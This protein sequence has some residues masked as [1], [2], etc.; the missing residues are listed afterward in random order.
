MSLL[1]CVTWADR[2]LI[3][4]DTI[5]VSPEGRRAHYSK[6]IPLPHMPCIIAGRGLSEFLSAVA[7]TVNDKCADFDAVVVAFGQIVAD[8]RANAVASAPRPELSA[9]ARFLAVGWSQQCRKMLVRI[10]RVDDGQVTEDFNDGRY[11]SPYE[12]GWDVDVDADT[13]ERLYGLA[14]QQ[15]RRFN[16]EHAPVAMCGG[17]S[18]IAELTRESMTITRRPIDE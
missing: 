2:A 14:I 6:L 8:I 7:G 15:T 17:E 3:C 10:V 1:N 18:I 12:A 13:P 16:S 4:V 9:T 5:G 11:I